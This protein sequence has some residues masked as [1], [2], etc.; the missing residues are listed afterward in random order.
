MRISGAFADATAGLGVV[1]KFSSTFALGNLD[2][3]LTSSPSPHWSFLAEVV[4]EAGTDNGVGIDLERLQATFRFDERLNLTLGRVHQS[5]GYYNTAY[6]HGAYLQPAISRPLVV[7]F[8]DQGGLLPVHL[9]GL[10]AQGEFRGEVLTF[11]YALEV[12]NGRGVV[13]DSV[14]NSVDLNRQKSINALAYVLIEPLQLR[15]GANALWD[16]I[17]PGP[18]RPALEEQIF[19]AHARFEHRAFSFLVETYLSRARHQGSEDSF[20]LAG[21]AEAAYLGAMLRPYLRGEWLTT[22]GAPHLFLAE[23]LPA[24][25][26]YSGSVGLGIEAWKRVVIKVQFNAAAA[27]SSPSAGLK[28]QVAF[29]F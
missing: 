13:A 11:G 16:S 9:V 24:S 14:L 26:R 20:T 15:V 18:D 10:S 7:S 27:A 28:V 25:P 3:F 4:L 5:L 29:A 22:W 19:G 1:P 8:E 12:G 2:L 17:P 6:H 23:A 21:F